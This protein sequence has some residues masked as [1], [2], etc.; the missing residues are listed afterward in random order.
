MSFRPAAGS[1]NSA[2]SVSELNLG[3][4]GSVRLVRRWRFAPRAEA[5]SQFVRAAT[6]GKSRSRQFPACA[7]LRASM[8]QLLVKY[9]LQYQSGV[10]AVQPVGTNMSFK[11]GRLWRAPAL[12]HGTAPMPWTHQQRHRRQSAHAFRAWAAPR[13]TYESESRRRA[14]HIVSSAKRSARRGPE[15]SRVARKVQPNPSLKRSANGGPPGPR[16]RVV[17]HRPRGPGVPPSSPAYLKR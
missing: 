2:F 7:L 17:Y 4:Q 3:S 14:E 9:P 13:P 10:V 5:R 16:G 11:Q 1:T 12:R 15:S 6:G 8:R